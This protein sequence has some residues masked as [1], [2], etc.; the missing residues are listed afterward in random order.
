[1]ELIRTWCLKWNEI[2]RQT[3]KALFRCKEVF[4]N[5]TGIV[6]ISRKCWLIHTCD[7][8]FPKVILCLACTLSWLQ[9]STRVDWKG[10]VRPVLV[11]CFFFIFFFFLACSATY[12][13]TILPVFKPLNSCFPFAVQIMI[14]PE[15]TCTNRSCLI[16]FKPGNF[17]CTS[18]FLTQLKV[19]Q[20]VVAF[21]DG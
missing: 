12:T 8:N 10:E 7:I 6:V 16:T 14:F 11:L 15:G 18:S 9:S 2:N 21:P 4:D 17:S 20:H 5:I 19:A 1:M 3:R 13:F